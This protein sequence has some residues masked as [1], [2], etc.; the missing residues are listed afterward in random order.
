MALTMSEVDRQVLAAIEADL[1]Q[2]E[3]IEAAIQEAIDRLRPS[4]EAAAC[5]RQH[6]ERELATV[7]QTLTRFVAAI[8]A[9]GDVPTLVKAMRER[10]QTRAELQAQLAGLTG[11]E[12]IQTWDP[13]QLRRDLTNRLA[14]WQG[15]L[16]RHV[17]QTRQILRKLLVGRLRFTFDTESQTCEFTGQGVFDPILAGML[18][19]KAVVSPTGFVR[20]GSSYRAAA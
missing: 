7:E 18:G 15:L 2:P 11:L 14:Q 6:L 1:L 3:I 12:R 17:A 8:E 4:D 20:Q 10:E 9:G 5:Q 13:Q 16:T 19:P